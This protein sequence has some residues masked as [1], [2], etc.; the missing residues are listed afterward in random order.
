MQFLLPGM[1]PTLCRWEERPIHPFAP[2][3]LLRDAN[4]DLTEVTLA[5]ESPGPPEA[6]GPYRRLSESV[7]A[8]RVFGPKIGQPVILT[9]R[10]DPGETIG[11]CYR[12]M[13]GLRLFFASRV[14]EVFEDEVTE[15]GWRSGFVYQTLVH[16]PEV[17]E[18][19]FEI[20]KHRD[21]TVTF[22]LEAWSRPNLWFVKLFRSWARRIQK[23]AARCAVEYLQSV[24]LER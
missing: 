6:N 10:V 2:K 18:E 22:R 1:T 4:H 19:I 3:E 5:V 7:L 8:Y 12:F 16:H 23:R 9:H 13:P 11:L 20:H 21:G 15:E 17:G 24:A 14:V